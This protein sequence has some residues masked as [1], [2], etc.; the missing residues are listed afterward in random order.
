[1]RGA[2]TASGSDW[3]A[4]ALAIRNWIKALLMTYG[5]RAL[6]ITDAKWCERLDKMRTGDGRPI[7]ARLRI[8]IER[9][10]KR[11]KVVT[12]QVRE[13]EAERDRLVKGS[14]PSGDACTERCASS[15]SCTVSAPS[16]PQCSRG[17]S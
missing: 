8:E 7:P 9:E 3:C 16:L 6:R 5:I 13:V 2:S 12:E 10:W 14:E 17:K 15:S 1:M 4:N 11:L